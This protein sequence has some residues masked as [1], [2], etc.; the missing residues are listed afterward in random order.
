MRL[1]QITDTHF[2]AGWEAADPARTLRAVIDAVRGL[3]QRPDVV[4]H[5][6]DLTDSG[7]DADYA[8]LRDAL[9]EL[10]L[11]CH[12]IPGN[13]DDR[14]TMRRHF[15]LPGSGSG[16]GSDG[17][18]IQYVVELGELRVLM[19][20]T[21]HPGQASGQLDADRQGWIATTLAA[22]PD[23]PT[24][25]AMHHPPFVTG[26]TGMD[27]IGLLAADRAALAQTLAD[28]PQVVGVIAGH[29]HRT[30]GSSVAGRPALTIPGTGCQVLLDFDAPDG[31]M[32]VEP[33][34]FAVHTLIDGRLVSHVQT[35]PVPG[36]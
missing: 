6:G 16:S 2:G 17:E 15:A 34:G 22:A 30:I 8:A 4:I 14:A 23:T 3:P 12:L 25:L 24:L 1:L 29:V 33:L 32:G 10:Q 18:P 13:H 7:A 20:D 35:V 21:V 9:A 19:L 27:S 36:R 28:H 11:P 31:P 5:T 26:L